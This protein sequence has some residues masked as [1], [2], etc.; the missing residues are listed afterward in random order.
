VRKS[1]REALRAIKESGATDVV[2]SEGGR[3]T[4]V[5]FINAS[6]KPQTATLH[7]GEK[8]TQ[9]AERALRA[10]LRNGGKS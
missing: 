1:L 2:V 6:G 3:H 4:L 9:R 8:T 5:D 10:Q 7:R